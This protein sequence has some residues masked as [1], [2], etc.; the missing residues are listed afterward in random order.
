MTR[1]WQ[2]AKGWFSFTPTIGKIFPVSIFKYSV[3]KYVAK[4]L[5]SL[6]LGFVWRGAKDSKESGTTEDTCFPAC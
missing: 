6:D 4:F 3:H 2:I 5:Y 1:F